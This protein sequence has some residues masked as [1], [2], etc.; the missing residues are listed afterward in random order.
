MQLFFLETP[1]GTVK[2]IEGSVKA[3]LLN[4]RFTEWDEIIAYM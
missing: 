3:A 1:N 4:G 2:L